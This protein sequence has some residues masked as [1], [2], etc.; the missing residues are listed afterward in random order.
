MLRFGKSEEEF[1][2][3]YRTQFPRVRRT[4]LGMVGNGAVA[5]ELAQEAFLKAWR[6][7][8]QFGLRSS[9]KTWLYQ[10]AINVGRDW[11]RSHKN[12]SPIAVEE[13]DPA[14]ETQGIQDSLQELD[15]DTRP[16][17]VLFYYEGMK[18]KELSLV[19][20]L[21]EGT[22]KSRLHSAKAKLRELLLMR[23]FDV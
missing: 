5:D 20:K 18:I 23:G 7:L 14:P 19:L 15:D 4:L 22:V 2:E 13:D 16:L 17:L 1:Q 12:R 11:L 10:V 21:P 6:G 3:L 8:S 9:L